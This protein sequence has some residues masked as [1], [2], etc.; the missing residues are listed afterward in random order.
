MADKNYD[1]RRSSV[2]VG[3]DDDGAK[4]K[5]LLA[6]LLG[7]LA[8]IALIALIA[9]CSG[10][11]D[12]KTKSSTPSTPTASTPSTPS[13]SLPATTPTTPDVEPTPA[14]GG[15][16]AA[17]LTAASAS[18]L[19]QDAATIADH[20]GDDATGK[21]LKVLSV[22]EGGFFVGTGD[23][24]R[25]YVEYGGNVGEDESDQQLPSVGDVV[26]LEGPVREAPADPSKT[27][28]LDEADAKL[29]TERGAY[30]NADKVTP[31]G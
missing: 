9:S 15:A 7:L 30:V 11:D 16:T 4:K 18:L 21:G 5:R 26:S 17:T 27:L 29:V 6:L 20:V 28:K 25:Q 24:D 22:N 12:K 14:A 31:A 3:G 2:A 10:D 1:P 23:A 8:L 13:T 19:D